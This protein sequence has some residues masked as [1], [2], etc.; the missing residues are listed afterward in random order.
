MTARGWDDLS[1]MIKLYEEN[2]I[3]VDELLIGQYLQDQ[4]ISKDFAIYY[5]LFNKYRNDYK[6]EAILAGKADDNIIFR[7]RRAPIDERLSLLGLLFDAVTNVMKAVCEKEDMLDLL[8]PLLRKLKAEFLIPERSDTSGATGKMARA[9]TE[10]QGMTDGDEQKPFEVLSRIIGEQEE[11]LDKGRRA[12][13]ITPAKQKAMQHMLQVLEAF[14]KKILI[15]GIIDGG[16]AFELIKMLFEKEVDELKKAAKEGADTLENAFAFCE[17]AFCV[18]EKGD[19]EMLVFVT[20]LTVNYFTARFIGH[21]GCEK[22]NTHNKAL[23]L[24]QRQMELADKA[25]KIEWNL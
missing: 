12:S 4:K 17:K 25:A 15:D 9:G 18:E 2:G 13:A 3:E 21:Y 20:E 24:A 19:D 22:Y 8:T 10:K 11:I 6:I 16:K 5:D 1:E 7:A 14:R 23:Q